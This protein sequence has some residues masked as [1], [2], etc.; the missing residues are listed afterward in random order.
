MESLSGWNLSY[1]N[2]LSRIAGNIRRRVGLVG[3]ALAL[4]WANTIR[5]RTL[6][7]PIN[8]PGSIHRSA[9]IH[10]PTF[11]PGVK[12]ALSDK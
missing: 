12:V 5:L 11:D 3:T 8:R 1:Q 6:I 2:E 7:P 10:W 9:R 4:A